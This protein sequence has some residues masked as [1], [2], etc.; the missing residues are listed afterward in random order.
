MIRT[1]QRN[2]SKNEESNVN[3][4]ARAYIILQ[5]GVC[6][7]A[8]LVLCAEAARLAE[9]RAFVV[10]VNVGGRGEIDAHQH[11]PQHH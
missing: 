11:L 3:P 6:A 8:A 10:L 2:E 4:I 9:L 5:V 7:L 1:I